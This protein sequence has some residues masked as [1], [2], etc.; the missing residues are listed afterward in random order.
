M[1]THPFKEYLGCIVPILLFIGFIAYLYTGA[2][3]ATK[4]NKNDQPKSQVGKYLYLDINNTLHVRIYCSAI[5]KQIG[6]IGAVDR[7]VTRIPAESV[8]HE[9]LDY[10][11][12]KCVSDES[13]EELKIIADANN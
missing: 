8:T 10:S 9:M 3:R 5:G 12:S 13:Y 4:T 6:E 7:A 2:N 11:C 1:S